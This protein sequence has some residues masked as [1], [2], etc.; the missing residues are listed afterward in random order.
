MFTYA[1][2]LAE[3]G[4]EDDSERLFKIRDILAEILKA[5]SDRSSSIIKELL[6]PEVLDLFNAED[7]MR[8]RLHIDEWYYRET[9]H[10]KSYLVSLFGMGRK[11]L[12]L[13]VTYKEYYSSNELCLK[14]NAAWEI[15]K[16]FV[17]DP[18]KLRRGLRNKLPESLFDEIEKYLYT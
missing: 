7:R 13:F 15:S 3:N 14:D 12:Y 4:R 8:L 16:I 9:P 11:P 6:L 2:K 10:K 17:D 1:I 18:S 5:G